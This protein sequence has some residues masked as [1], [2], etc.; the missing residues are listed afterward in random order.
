MKYIKNLF[1]SLKEIFII[2]ILEYILLIS[3]ILIFGIEKAITYGTLILIIFFIIYILYKLRN[4]KIIIKKVCYLPYILIGASTAV[5]FN[6]IIFKFGI[7][8]EVTAGIPLWLNILS[9]GIVSPIFEEVLFRYDFINK[10]KKFNSSNLVIILISSIIFGICHNNSVTVMY[11]IIVGFINSYLYIKH[12]NLLIPI[13]VHISGNLIV[14]LL[15]GY[16]IWILLLSIIL[17]FISGVA[18]YKEK[19]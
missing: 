5:T 16:N 4:K 13:I 9:S 2:L 15:F 18:I 6:M 1:S 8:F 7:T 10:L 14:N 17:F 11:A 19:I 3:I 12:N